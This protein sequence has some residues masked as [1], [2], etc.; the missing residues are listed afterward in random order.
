MQVATKIL[1]IR[2]GQTDWNVERRVMGGR[3]IPLNATG[4]AQMKAV[5]AMLS[6]LSIDCVYHSPHLR[7]EESATILASAHLS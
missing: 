4:R 6:G 7:T 2:H 1:L 3:P 5:R